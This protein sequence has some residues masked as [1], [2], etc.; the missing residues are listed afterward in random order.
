MAALVGRSAASIPLVHR[1]TDAR[2]HARCPKRCTISRRRWLWSRVAVATAWRCA[3]CASPRAE[4]PAPRLA[5]R[6]AGLRLVLPASTTS[7]RCTRPCSSGRAMAARRGFLDDRPLAH[8]RFVHGPAGLALAPAAACDSCKPALTPLRLLLV[9][10]ACSGGWRPGRCAM[11]EDDADLVLFLPLG[12]MLALIACR[13]GSPAACASDARRDAAAL[14]LAA[15]LY[16]RFD[17]ARPACSS[18]AAVD[19][20]VGLHYQHRRRRHQP[21]GW[22]C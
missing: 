13:H 9:S 11:S 5:P 17:A 16:V 3:W 19:R 6:L 7:T 20:R 22:S 12:G 21:A 8:R 15:S 2:R 18:T 10:V 14:S 4:R 1:G